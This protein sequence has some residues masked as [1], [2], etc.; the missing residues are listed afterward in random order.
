MRE[1]DGT[2]FT[3]T[4]TQDIVTIDPVPQFRRPLAKHLA[5]AHCR[6]LELS[7]TS[8]WLFPPSDSQELVRALL[9]NAAR[10]SY[11]NGAA[12]QQSHFVTLVPQIG[13]RCRAC[14]DKSHEANCEQKS[15]TS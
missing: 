10:V 2:E 4:I 12:F 9:R 5:D 11:C 15:P 13:A 8:D 14:D 1:T 3:V 7:F 6:W